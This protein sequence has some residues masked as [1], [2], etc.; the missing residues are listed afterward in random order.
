MGNLP[1]SKWRKCFVT[2]QRQLLLVLL[3]CF[4]LFLIAHHLATG[5]HCVPINRQS[6]TSALQSLL[7]EKFW[8]KKPPSTLSSFLLRRRSAF[9]RSTRRR[10]RGLKGQIWLFDCLSV[11]KHINKV[12]MLSC[13]ELMLSL[14]HRV[15]I[16]AMYNNLDASLDTTVFT[17]YT[18]SQEDSQ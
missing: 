11:R 5:F 12:S 16:P 14:A 17:Q 18:Q 8:R 4:S 10:W 15:D 9:W 13:V 6:W 1:F 2:M 7:A 3:V